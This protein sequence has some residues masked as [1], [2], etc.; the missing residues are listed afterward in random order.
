[1]SEFEK[2]VKKALI[3]HDMTMSDL[4]EL[5]GISLSYTSDL[6]KGKRSNTTRI[7]AITEIL[8]LQDAVQAPLPNELLDND[9]LLVGSSERPTR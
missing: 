8:G 3:E 7:G 5:L 4:A 9:H 1:M 2:T 6:I